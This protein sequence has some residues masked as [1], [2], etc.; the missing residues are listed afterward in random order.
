MYEVEVKYALPDA[1]AFER[2]LE[3]FGGY[4]GEPAEEFDVFYRHPARN[5]ADSDE[6]LRFRRRVL[7]DNSGECTLTYK[8]PKV[9]KQ[10]KTRREIEI[11]VESAAPWN[12]LLTA[13]GFA[14]GETVYKQRRSCSVVF[15]GEPINTVLDFLPDLAERGGSGTFV[16]LETFADD[17]TLDAKRQVLLAFAEQLGLT[18]SIQKSYLA[19]LTR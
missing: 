2:Q 7:P 13:L 11:A 1:A 8:G 15:Q 6:C 18:E 10:T 9:D 3:R 17:E 16:E 14:P 12:E 4:F 19:L 5:F